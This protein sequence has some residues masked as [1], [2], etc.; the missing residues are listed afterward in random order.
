MLANLLGDFV[1]L[2]MSP[3]LMLAVDEIVADGHVV[4]PLVSG[5]QQN[6][7]GPSELIKNAFSHAHGTRC[8]VSGLAEFDRDIHTDDS[9]ART[10]MSGPGETLAGSR[11]PVFHVATRT[12]ALLNNRPVNE[13][14]SLLMLFD[15]TAVTTESVGAAI[16]MMIA[17]GEKTVTEVLALTGPR[18]FVNTMQPLEDIGTIAMIA[19]GHGPFLGQVSTDEI[20]RDSGRQAEETLNKWVLDLV[21][22]SEVYAAVCDYSETDEAASLTGERARILDHSLRDFRLAGHG[23]D[24]VTRNRVQTLRT[25]LVELEIEFATNIAEFDDGIEIGPDDLDGLPDSYVEGLSAGSSQGTYRV[26]MAYPDV[27]P[28]LDNSSRRDLRE[29]LAFKFGNRARET[30]STVLDETLEIRAEIAGLF[31]T[32]SWAHY[33]MEVKMAKTPDAVEEFY[34]SLLDPL[35]T[36]GAAEIDALSNLLEK[37]GH[38]LPVQS[39]D[40]AYYHTQQMKNDYG[41]DPE[42]VASYFSLD[43][44][45]EG[46]FA[47]TQEVFGLNYEAVDTPVWHPDVRAY[48]VTDAASGDHIAHFYMDL[49]PREG[50]YNHAAAFPL[51]P[52]GPNVRPVSAIVANFTKPTDDKPSL[53][54]HDEVVTLFHEFGHILHMSLSQADFARFSSA[55]TEWDF[56]EAPS[57]IM[58]NWCWIPSVLDRFARHHKTGEPIPRELVNQLVAARDLNVAL[59]TLRQMLFGRIDMDIHNTLDPVDGESIVRSRSDMSLLPFHEGTYFLA[60]FGH[61]LGGYDAGYYGYLWSHVFGQ[62]MFSRFEEEGVLSPSIG[63]EYRQTI[64]EPNGTEDA[65]DL[66][67]NFLG[68]E[69]RSDAFL[70]KL[71]ISR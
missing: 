28:F 3:S 44:A 61:L 48:R 11:A 10:H 31:G 37:D 6:L 69:P 42:E 7:E 68:R 19:Y 50:K 33:S 57:Q 53:L 40:R 51:V 35:L 63:M 8:V 23:L 4:D 66:L 16:D 38:E 5:D 9:T 32:A 27:V 12:T 22:R 55:N 13:V 70:D 49:F 15:Y 26:S 2:G 1:P 36:M 43:R 21:S 46:L 25:R 45:V 60:S 41:V 65:H 47:I 20:V 67:R 52:S 54:Q 71:G 58:E 18:T 14:D 62:D 29:A 24:E 17:A 64:L 30:N 39:W 56:V 34:A 59:F